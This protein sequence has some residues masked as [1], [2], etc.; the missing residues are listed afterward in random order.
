[1]EAIRAGFFFIA[2]Y[3]SVLLLKIQLSE[4]EG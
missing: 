3:I 1:V 4:R 2:L